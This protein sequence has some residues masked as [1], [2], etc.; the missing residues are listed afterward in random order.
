MIFIDANLLTERNGETA[1][2]W[3]RNLVREVRCG[4]AGKPGD[5]GHG[6]LPVSVCHVGEL[7]FPHQKNMWASCMIPC[8]LLT[9]ISPNPTTLRVELM[10]SPQKQ[11][12]K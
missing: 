12:T 3:V 10:G 9:C 8:V 4:W 7:Q 11:I 5:G 6:T 1:T 2:F